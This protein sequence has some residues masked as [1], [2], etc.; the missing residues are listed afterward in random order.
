M[1]NFS[2]VDLGPKLLSMLRKF[3]PGD[4]KIFVYSDNTYIAERP[5]SGGPV[6]LVSL[7]GKQYEVSFMRDDARNLTYFFEG[8]YDMN[9]P[10]TKLMHDI[11]A[12]VREYY[13]ECRAVYGK[14]VFDVIG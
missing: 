14:H 10:D 9:D 5:I 1:W 8:M 4:M 6:K 7:D 3:Q 2:P 13:T 11:F 12:D